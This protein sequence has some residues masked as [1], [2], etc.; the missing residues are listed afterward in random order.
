MRKTVVLLDL[1]SFKHASLVAFLGAVAFCVNTAPAAP[2]ID[3]SVRALFDTHCVSCHDADSKKGG[4]DLSSVSGDFKTQFD[5]WLKIH[6]RIES[7]EM[8]PA[9]A[10]QRPTAAETE[11]VL[12]QLK[13]QLTGA[14]KSRRQ[15]GDGR[16]VY[17]RLNRTEYENTLRDLLALP[18]LSVKNLLPD[19]GR[20]NGYDKLAG[21][22]DLSHV[23]LSKYLEAADVA[24]TAATAPHAAWPQVYKN[25]LYAGDSYAFK[26]VLTN[27]D[28]IPIKDFKYDDT[29]L[30]IIREDA[31]RPKLGEM[32]KEKKFPYTGSVGLFR[33]E[34]DA[35]R[36]KFNPF[37]A[38]YAGRYRLR[39]SLW[40]FQYDKG[41]ILPSLRTEQ[42][43]LRADSRLI[44]YYDAPSLKPT[45]HEV[46]VWLN[47][48]EEIC[49]NAASLWP[50]RVSERKGKAAEYVGP[51]IAVDWLD[52]EG[53]IFEQWPP[54]SHQQLW[55]D[56][57]L[58][59]IP[60]GKPAETDPR[61]PKRTPIKAIRNAPRIGPITYGA[62]TSAAPDTDATRL[63]K[64]FLRRAFRRT[65]STEE[66][67]R[68]LGLFKSQLSDGAGFEEAMRTTYEAALCSPE[69]LFLKE[70]AGRLDPWAVASRLS[71]FL[72]NSA[73]DDELL[74][75]A[76]KNKLGQKDVLREQVE[77]MLKDPRSERFVE[78]FTDQWLDLRD[79]DSTT[80]DGRL[81]PEFRPNLRDA[82]LAESRAY[83]RAMV[84]GDL[85]TTAVVDSDFAFLNQRLA[86]HYR[87]PGVEGSAFRKVSLPPDAHRGG[88]LTQASVLKVTANGT[89]TSPVKRGA[90][91]QRKIVGRPPE[92]PPP[93]VPAIE[94]DVQGA[95]TVRELLDK[96]RNNAA[97]AACHTRIDPPG[98]ALESYD[99]IGGWQER[100]RS[101]GQGD[102]V[103]K[104]FSFG[105]AASYK[106]G[107]KV[108]SAG[109]TADGRA[110][111]EI[112]GFKKLLLADEKALARNLV[113]HLVI[114]ATGAPVGFTDRQA[115]EQVLE[116]SAASKYG[117]KT[118]IHEIVQSPLFLSK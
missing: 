19:D 33:H 15:P 108:D 71:F 72:W 16:A 8:P 73:P 11:P 9:K 63:L 53:P 20:V 57:P 40:S 113:N 77:R 76:E 110:F 70:P 107:P 109:Q 43:S 32:E 91:V 101:L 112:A 69:F 75:L 44:G 79:I 92:P 78:D 115:V 38:S 7:G 28:A 55:G 84:D 64:D 89:T 88:L 23:Q 100:Y 39:I 3:K 17:R 49:Y 27:G 86:E 51:G 60:R 5:T 50:V 114:Y 58:A 59:P 80:P 102:A 93:D 26:I 34:D 106:F 42:A 35:F 24:L 82:M 98:F 10:K 45:V 68:Y 103:P 31:D 46:E 116:K 25:R 36:P 87:I 2:A 13:S 22:L 30:P 62:V 83:F 37:I 81:Y 14:E 97:C 41:Q 52:V 111:D 67:N 12:K 96:H 105:R 6:D 18:G 99:V 47:E 85:P 1:R 65:V 61:L 21:A 74:S 118:L 56:L 66:V 4:L 104:E 48:G 117:I 90:W 95:T 54:A 94:P 29:L